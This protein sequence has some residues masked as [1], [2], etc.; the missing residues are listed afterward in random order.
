MSCD[1]TGFQVFSF[2]GPNAKPHIL[3][4]LSKHYNLRIDLKL[5]NGKCTI[6]RI[7]CAGTAGT[8]MLDKPWV[9]V[10]NPTRHLHYQTVEYCTYWPVL[11]YFNNWIII[12]F[13]NKT[14]TN[15]D[16]DTVHKVV[17]DGI[18]DNMSATIHN[19]K[20]GVINIADTTTMGYYVTNYLS[21]PYTLQDNKIVDKQVIKSGEFIVKAEYLSITKASTNWY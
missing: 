4:G 6:R 19:G 1:S 9:K 2:C 11:G 15:K 18:S 5:G 12:Q 20:Y 13:T 3:R 10:S 7:P 21:E 14:T 8:T 17:L 16:F